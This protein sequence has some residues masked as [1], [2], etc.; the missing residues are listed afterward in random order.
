MKIKHIHANVG[1]FNGSL[2]FLVDNRLLQVSVGTPHFNDYN[3]WRISEINFSLFPYNP[4]DNEVEL[5]PF[6]IKDIEI[7]DEDLK[8]LNFI[9]KWG[10]NHDKFEKGEFK[11]LK[12]QFPDVVDNLAGCIYKGDKRMTII[13]EDYQINLADWEKGEKTSF[14]KVFYPILEGFR[15]GHIKR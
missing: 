11:K 10:E 13:G 15:L 2:Y 1:L 3:E 12:K 6:K 8:M 7:N 5:T 14:Q 4:K 9:A